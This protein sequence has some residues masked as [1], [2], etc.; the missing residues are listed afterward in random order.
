[1]CVYHPMVSQWNSKTISVDPQTKFVLAFACLAHI[2]TRGGDKDIIGLGLDA[3]TF[4]EAD[5]F[6]MRWMDSPLLGATDHTVAVW[7]MATLL[8]L[9]PGTYVQT[10]ELGS[11]YVVL[12]EDDIKGIYPILREGMGGHDGA[13]M[14]KMLSH[15]QIPANR[16]AYTQI[17]QNVH[18]KRTWYTG[19]HPLD[20]YPRTREAFTNIFYGVSSPMEHQ[21]AASMSKIRSALAAQ[22]GKRY[23]LDIKRSFDRADN[24]ILNVHLN[25]AR[26]RPALLKA[27]A[28]ITQEAGRGFSSEEMDWILTRS[29]K[30][31]SE[32]QS[33][34]ILACTTF[35]TNTVSE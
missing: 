3:P 14:V 12:S 21:I 10:N 16:D 15:V 32:L 17:L 35:R 5:E 7:G 23:G 20:S 8:D 31:P 26:N 29:E 25:R 13:R 11:S 6:H 2:F 18:L 28:T 24:L 1:M 34:L 19:V 33:L 22:Y 4:S 30:H 27:L 9:P